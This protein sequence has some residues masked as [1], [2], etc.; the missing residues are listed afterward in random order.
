LSD[1]ASKERGKTFY[2]ALSTLK[3]EYFDQI[4]N[5]NIL[6]LGTIYRFSTIGKGSYRG[7]T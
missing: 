2:T 1:V 6:L 7:E 4:L 3:I 5:E